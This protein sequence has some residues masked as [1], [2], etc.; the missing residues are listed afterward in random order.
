MHEQRLRPLDDLCLCARTKQ[1]M[2]AGGRRILLDTEDR[3]CTQAVALHLWLE[4]RRA[5]PDDR[6]QRHG[7]FSDSLAPPRARRVGRNGQAFVFAALGDQRMTLGA[8]QI[9]TA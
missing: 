2:S 7:R 1:A 8:H 3:R 4:D 5:A 9:F 6:G